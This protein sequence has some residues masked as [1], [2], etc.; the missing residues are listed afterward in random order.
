MQSKPLLAQRTLAPLRWNAFVFSLFLASGLLVTSG[1]A[2]AQKADEVT[3][4]CVP[5]GQWQIPADDSQIKESRLLDSMAKRPVVLLGESHTSAEHHR[6][7]LHVLSALYARNPNMV[8]GFEAF[9]RT[10]QPVLDRWSR[11]E[12][13]EKQFLEL[14]KWNDV[15]GYDANIYMPLFHFARMHRLPMRALNVEQEFIR[16]ISRDGW[17]SITSD[18]R[19]GISDP[20]APSKAYRESLESIFT[21]HGEKE[22]KKEGKSELIEEKKKRL[23]SFVEVQTTWDRAMAEALATVRTAGGEPLVVAIVG[24]GHVEY[25]Y[26]ISHQLADL[27]I[28]NP[29]VLLPWDKELPCEEMKTGDGT[30]VADA[31]FGVDE[32]VQA[33]KPPSPMLGVQIENTDGEGVKIVK[34]VKNSVAETTGLK[35]GDLIIQAAGLKISKTIELVTTIRKQAP[36]TW[37]PLGIKRDGK[38]MDML[39]KFPAHTKTPKHP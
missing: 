19:R 21:M 10:M 18:K 12:L 1:P 6:W 9:P 38:R 35:K 30:P 29:A 15:W 24:R 32:P 8:L 3:F 22:D 7:Q 26:G 23:K 17:A 25:G 31:V 33:A 14:S 13:S 4:A 34:V 27:G 36:G 2:K 20:A 28:N 5:A 16:Q 37:L 39:A 11:G